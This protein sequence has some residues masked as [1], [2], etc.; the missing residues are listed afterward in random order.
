MAQAPNYFFPARAF[1]AAPLLLSPP[2]VVAFVVAA[3]F[4]GAVAAARSSW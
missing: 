4:A 1:F 2:F 3:N